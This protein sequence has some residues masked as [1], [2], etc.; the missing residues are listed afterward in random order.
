MPRLDADAVLL[1]HD[2]WHRASYR[3]PLLRHFDLLGSAGTLVLLAPRR[4]IDAAALAVDLA[5]HALRSRLIRRL[6]G[7]INP[8]RLNPVFI[9]PGEIGRMV[10]D[11]PGQRSEGK[12]ACR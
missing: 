9:P 2:F 12:P 1:V 10:P 11:D 7:P 6:P 4:P 5:A 3:R 8:G